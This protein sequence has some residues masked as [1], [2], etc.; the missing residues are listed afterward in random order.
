MQRH[1]DVPDVPLPV[2][3]IGPRMAIALP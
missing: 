3:P 2:D 1:D